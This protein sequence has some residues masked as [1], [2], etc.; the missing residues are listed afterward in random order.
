MSEKSKP[1]FKREF[2]GGYPVELFPN[3]YGR[4]RGTVARVREL[5]DGLP[6]ELLTTEVDGTWSMQR[7]IGH[8]ID[9][10][11]LWDARLNDY[12]AASS[13]LSPADLENRATHEADHDSRSIAEL[14][15]ELSEV[16]IA[17]LVRIASLSPEQC[18][19]TSLHPRLKL[20]MRLIDLLFFVAEHDDHHIA[21]LIELERRLTG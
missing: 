8:L 10:E 17:F 20:P 19:L 4:L 21:R 11:T 2:P 6:Q 9:L 16:R 13:V 1:W 5:V 15:T 7:N 12:F 3:L 14:I 18:E